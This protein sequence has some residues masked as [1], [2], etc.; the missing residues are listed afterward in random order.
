M[1]TLFQRCDSIRVRSF[2]EVGNKVKIKNDE[3]M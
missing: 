2:M 3:E 1:G